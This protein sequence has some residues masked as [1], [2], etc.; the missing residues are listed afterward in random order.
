ML[1][2]TL[3]AGGPEAVKLALELVRLTDLAAAAEKLD[4]NRIQFAAD[5]ELVPRNAA[6]IDH[7]ADVPALTS[8][9]CRVRR[10]DCPRAQQCELFCSTR[11]RSR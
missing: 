5:E 1:G 11:S 4:R 8:G 9:K 6:R 7:E 10:D 3:D 2:E